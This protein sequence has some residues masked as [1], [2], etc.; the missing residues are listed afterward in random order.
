MKTQLIYD[1]SLDVERSFWDVKTSKEVFNE[2]DP[3]NKD[4]LVSVI[5]KKREV[6]DW[7]LDN[8]GI[9][10]FITLRSLINIPENLT[11]PLLKLENAGPNSVT[12]LKLV[13]QIPFTLG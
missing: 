2:L 5:G 1:T 7:V 8:I 6:Q 3:V 12:K 10:W 11:T 9:D 4:F 13:N